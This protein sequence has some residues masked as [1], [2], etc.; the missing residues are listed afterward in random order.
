VNN[1]ILIGLEKETT[2]DFLREDG[3]EKKKEEVN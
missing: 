2:S 1:R 3:G